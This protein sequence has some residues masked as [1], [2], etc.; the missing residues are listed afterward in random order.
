MRQT[1][2]GRVRGVPAEGGG[3]IARQ[4]YR[5]ALGRALAA[6]AVDITSTC[7]R[8]YHK[9]NPELEFEEVVGDPLWHV[10]SLATTSI[11][12]WLQTGV[13]ADADERAEIASV[14]DAAAR[15]A[16]VVDGPSGRAIGR[17]QPRQG[18]PAATPAP[19]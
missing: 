8:R 7:Q 3:G 4:A 14:G 11:A 1:E 2:R 19:A 5:D 9:A 16:E 12:R 6:R 17:P 18:R 10:T 15:Q 13:A